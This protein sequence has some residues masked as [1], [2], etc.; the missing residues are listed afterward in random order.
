MTS[1]SF[2]VILYP[3]IWLTHIV[4]SLL[5]IFIA[6]QRKFSQSEPPNPCTVIDAKER[7]LYWSKT[8][9]KLAF[10]RTWDRVWM[11]I[12]N[13]NGMSLWIKYP[14]WHTENKDISLLNRFFCY[15]QNL[16]KQIL[17]PYCCGH[18]IWQ[19]STLEHH[20]TDHLL[21]VPWFCP[22]CSAGKNHPEG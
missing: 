18:Q 13:E 21:D 7:T 5:P 15:R 19:S 20:P 3:E 1:H 9:G 4:V 14:R 8:E 10:P 16:V 6:R 17:C 2:R 22:A 12:S 11:R